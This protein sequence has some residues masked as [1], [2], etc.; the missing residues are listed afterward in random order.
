MRPCNP[1]QK[2]LGTIVHR[3]ICFGAGFRS[4]IAPKLRI[5]NRL[6]GHV[7]PRDIFNLKPAARKPG[8]ICANFQQASCYFVPKHCRRVPTSVR[9]LAWLVISDRLPEGAFF[10]DASYGGNPR[11]RCCRRK[12][13]SDMRDKSIKCLAH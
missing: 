4:Q 6:V 8:F 9:G 7:M 13:I 5:G 1:K 11:A 10:W 2:A 12:R 3:P